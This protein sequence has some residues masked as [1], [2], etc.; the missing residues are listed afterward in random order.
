[1]NPGTSMPRETVSAASLFL[2]LISLRWFDANKDELMW[3]SFMAQKWIEE[4]QKSWFR[5][6]TSAA[7]QHYDQTHQ[8]ARS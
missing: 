1:M 4:V 5:L 8:L 7:I 6:E 3:L 2:T